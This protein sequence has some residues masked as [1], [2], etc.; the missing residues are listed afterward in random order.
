MIQKQE[1][2]HIIFDLDGLL[3]DTEPFYTLVTQDILDRYGK[4]FDWSVK[5]KMMGKQGRDSCKILVEA[6]DLPI[7]AQEFLKE[8]EKKLE[9][10]FPKAPLMPG[11][12]Q[13]TRYF[14]RHKI[15]Q[16]IA[17][18]SSSHSFK[19]KIQHHQDWLTLFNC[20]V[21]GDDPAVQNGKPAPDIFLLAAKR[22]K[23][24]PSFCLVFE[25]S[26]AGVTAAKA[27]GMAV[28]AVPDPN[29]NPEAVKAAD[30][31]LNSLAEFD[32]ILWGLPPFE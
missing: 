1:I 9:A 15:P 22:L 14:F 20:Y 21:T 31:T 19:L 5:S 28:I 7:S 6:L 29:I 8:R 10:L 18:S 30:Q 26:P 32:P 27:A 2:T 4:V 24:E 11:S 17:T 23:A 3:L 16:A 13:L 12:E 25:D